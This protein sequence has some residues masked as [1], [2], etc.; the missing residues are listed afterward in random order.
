VFFHWPLVDESAV[1]GIQIIKDEIIVL[2]PNGG[3]LS[4]YTFFSYDEVIFLAAPNP[5]NDINNWMNHLVIHKID[6][7]GHLGELRLE[8]FRHRA[9]FTGSSVR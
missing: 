8:I 6:S 2:Q 3:M 1:G 5:R 9:T 4:G 7:L